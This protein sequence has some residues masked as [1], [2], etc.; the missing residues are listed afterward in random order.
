VDNK[1][2][3]KD[4]DKHTGWRL[5]KEY[6]QELVRLNTDELKNHYLTKDNRDVSDII[7][8]KLETL[9]GILSLDAAINGYIDLEKIVEEIEKKEKEKK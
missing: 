7:R 8:G 1:E 4:L 2:A 9:E 5:L 6:L 3:I